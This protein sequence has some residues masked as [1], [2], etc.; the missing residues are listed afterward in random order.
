MEDIACKETHQYANA[1]IEYIQMVRDQKQL[2]QLLA[3][4][5]IGTHEPSLYVSFALYYEKYERNFK[6]ADEMY[7]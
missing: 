1:W 5:G 7:R 6:L 3:E 4:K 2:Y